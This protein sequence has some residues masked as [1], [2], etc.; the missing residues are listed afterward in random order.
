MRKTKAQKAL[1]AEIDR[2]FNKH[3]SGVQFRMLDLPKI[4]KAGETAFLNGQ[5]P[6]AAIVESIQT[7]R[8]N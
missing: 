4:H 2:L 1:D 6:E 8:L 7:L 5:D 3:G